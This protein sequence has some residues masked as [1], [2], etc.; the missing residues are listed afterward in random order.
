MK[1]VKNKPNTHPIYLDSVAVGVPFAFP[2]DDNVYVRLMEGYAGL[3]QGRI[4]TP[5]P[6]SA[7]WQEKVI[8]YPNAEL[9]L[10][11]PA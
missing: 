3:G 6:S 11:D 8:T 10:G 7:I 5:T 1:I 2:D 9:H 4:F